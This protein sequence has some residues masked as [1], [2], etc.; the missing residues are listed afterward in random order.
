MAK[1][2]EAQD[3]RGTPWLVYEGDPAWEVVKKLKALELIALPR[4]TLM[5][6]ELVEVEEPQFGGI[7]EEMLNEGLKAVIIRQTRMYDI[8]RFLDGA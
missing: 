1:A 7:T 2:I 3:E 5:T 4:K 8:W 6:G